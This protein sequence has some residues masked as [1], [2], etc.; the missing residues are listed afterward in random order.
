MFICW[1]GIL[2]S[3]LIE[4]VYK[5]PTFVSPL[6]STIFSF[7]ESIMHRL[8]SLRSKSIS[9]KSS[10]LLT[11]LSNSTISSIHKFHPHP[12]EYLP[13]HLSQ[14]PTFNQNSRFPVSAHGFHGFSSTNF[15]NLSGNRCCIRSF[16]AEPDRDS[17]EYDVVIVGAGPAGLS[18]GIRLKQ[19]CG[20][21]G[22]DLSVCIVEKGAE[23]GKV[24]LDFNRFRPE[25]SFLFGK[26]F[27]VTIVFQ[28]HIWLCYNRNYSSLTVAFNFLWW[29]KRKKTKSSFWLSFLNIQMALFLS[30]K[31]W[32]C[33]WDD[34]IS[35]LIWPLER[36]YVVG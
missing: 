18:A 12:C 23:V 33:F 31:K 16:S 13:K 27:N 34:M 36:K 3:N 14:N 1:R 10:A 7:R 11:H 5:Y 6:H 35:K 17:I 28:W 4:P 32:L 26:F 15:Q 21:N 19:L 29:K 8:I 9:T 30:Q 25:N 2:H 22:S 20:E 24:H